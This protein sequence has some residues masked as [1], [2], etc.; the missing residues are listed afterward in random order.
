MSAADWLR[1][2]SLF[3][4]L[5]E[6]E[7]TALADCLGRRVFTRDMI[8][9]HKGGPAQNLYIIESGAVRIFALSETG[10]EITLHVYG[11]RECFGE[12]ALLDGNLRSS[13]AM[14]LERTVVYTLR[15]D[16]FLRCLESHRQVARR[17]VELFAHRMEHA[18]AYA[19]HLAF[20][21]VAGRVAAVL[22][23]LAA[24]NGTKHGSVE[25]N[26]HLTQAELASWTC[27]SREMVGRVL[28]EYREQ[29]LIALEVHANVLQDVNGL[30]PRI[31]R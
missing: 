17:V 9:Y 11:P 27:A 19:E 23:D 4:D 22:L 26:L 28:H 1:R 30:K 10:H 20:M 14:A 29:G 18:I 16:N 13:G 2:V 6:D 15:R 31:S 21:D 7:L 3:A 5:S 25:I 12:T 24:R 8:L